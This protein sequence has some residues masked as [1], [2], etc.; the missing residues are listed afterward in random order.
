MHT[1]AYTHTQRLRIAVELSDKGA[2]G[3][4]YCSIGNCL[5]AMVQPEKA[6]ECY[7]RVQLV[8]GSLECRREG[9]R[10]G[11]LYIQ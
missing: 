8:G 9:G 10:E 11:G 6:I 3:K 5:K 1:H 4:S 7:T 2:E